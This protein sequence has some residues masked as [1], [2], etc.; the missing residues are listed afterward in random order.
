MIVTSKHWVFLP[1]LWWSTAWCPLAGGVCSDIKG[2]D[3]GW[4]QR[5][6]SCPRE[7]RS[8][9]AWAPKGTGALQGWGCKSGLVGT[10]GGGV[11]CSASAQILQFLSWCWQAERTLCQSLNLSLHRALSWSSVQKWENKWKKYKSCVKLIYSLGLDE[12]PGSCFLASFFSSLF[13][14]RAFMQRDYIPQRFCSIL[15]LVPCFCLFVLFEE[16]TFLCPAHSV[17]DFQS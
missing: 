11:C 12:D 9:R 2:W 14:R 5:C 1:E 16:K 3:T 6:S 4:E 8:S 7:S 13:K 15:D 17:G 10:G